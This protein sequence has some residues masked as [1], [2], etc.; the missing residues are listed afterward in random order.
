VRTRRVLAVLA[1][2]C[3]AAYLLGIAL[4]FFTGTAPLSWLRPQPGTGRPPQL[5][6]L[7]ALVPILLVGIVALVARFVRRRRSRHTATERSAQ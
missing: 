6:A 1:I 4:A 7:L 2:G 5:V 3:V